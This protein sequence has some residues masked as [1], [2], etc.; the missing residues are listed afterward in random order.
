M[1]HGICLR[2][3]CALLALLSIPINANSSTNPLD[4]I[5]ITGSRTE[6]PAFEVPQ[7]ISTITRKKIVENNY[8]TT[9][10]ALADTAGVLV[11]KTAHGQGSPFIRGLTGKQVLIL[12]DGVRLNNST[13]R[14]GPNQY[15]ATIDPS[16]IERIEVVR[17]PGSV[18]YGSDALGGVINIITRKRMDYYLPT[19]QNSELNLAYGSADNEQ[20]VRIATEGNVDNMGYWLGADARNF[21]DLR[22]GGDVGT[23]FYTGYDE[24]HANATLSILP[25]ENQRLDLIIQFTRQKDVPRTDKFINSNERRIFNPQERRFLSLQW[26]DSGIKNTAMDHLRASIN[27][28]LQHEALERQKFT[29]TTIKNYDDKISSTSLLLQ[30]DKTLNTKN[31]LSYGL[32][33]YRDRVKSTRVDSDTGTGISTLMRGNFPNGS[34]YSMTGV[35]L[36]N[37]YSFSNLS[38]ITAGIRFSSNNAQTTLSG[39]GN[40]GET[41]EN[42]TGSLRWSSEVKDGLR[43]FTGISQGFRAPNLDDI[44]VLKSTNEGEDVPSPGLKSE[45]S[46]NYEAGLKLNRAD[47]AGTLTTF[48]SDYTNLID[49]RPGTYQGLSFI[50]DNGNSIQDTGED[51]VVQKFNVGDATIYGIELDGQFTF[52]DDWSG[53]GNISWA[54]GLN[55][56]NSE[57]LSRIPPAKLMLG[58]RWKVKG[59][60][61]WLEP[62]AELNSKQERLSARDISDPRI[63]SG[64]TPGYSLLNL[65]GGWQDDLQSIDIALNNITDRKYKVHGSG[66]YGAGHEI[67]FS[68][69][70]RF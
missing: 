25:D 70:R 23:Q 36:Q 31:I 39:F 27:Y 57:P 15:L 24:Y 12:V 69:L 46:I 48:Y 42:I 35:Y 26:H 45:E 30:A 5:V 20:T 2:I 50:D 51:N 16:S 53:F 59:S 19:A 1:K 7:S 17:G 34:K 64:G 6:E 14:F 18:L 29:S 56:T 4:E 13:F 55:K 32:E 28:Q 60:P 67:K 21:D 9:P 3:C 62:T 37:E 11:Q 68:Y 49:R 65:R 44:A 33:H 38:T 41:Y 63:P 58:A 22:G 40:L 8:R 10:E 43:L 52:N 47:W 66:L 61:W 54:Y